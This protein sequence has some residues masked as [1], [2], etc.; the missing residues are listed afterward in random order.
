VQ[1]DKVVDTFMILINLHYVLYS[2]RIHVLYQQNNV[3]Y[4][5][6]LI[7]IDH[8]H[9]SISTGDIV[10]REMNVDMHILKLILL[11]LYVENSH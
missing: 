2:L 4:H 5:I 10:K 11:L 1:K 3:H 7:L 6:L 9:V 8:L